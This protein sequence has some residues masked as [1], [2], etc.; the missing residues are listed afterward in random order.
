MI[1]KERLKLRK[2]NPHLFSNNPARTF[3]GL[4][5]LPEDLV[6]SKRSLLLSGN[7]FV[8]RGK[9]MGIYI[10][11][12]W[13]VNIH[14]RMHGHIVVISHE[15]LCQIETAWVSLTEFR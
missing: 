3:L 7:L 6:K 10:F 4:K 15:E 11:G 13:Y 14:L 1:R 9:A 5:D 2:A 8:S 12:D